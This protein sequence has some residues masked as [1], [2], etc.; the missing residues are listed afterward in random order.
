MVEE[1]TEVL[2]VAGL[3]G[4]S[5]IVSGGTVCAG[6]AVVGMPLLWRLL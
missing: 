6:V 5:E 4:G 1:A 3:L 2:P